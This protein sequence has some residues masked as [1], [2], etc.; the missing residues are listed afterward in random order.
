[1]SQESEIRRH[2]AEERRKNEVTKLMQ[3]L[4][5]STNVMGGD[6][7]VAAGMVQGIMRSHRT[8]QQSFMR[9]F[10]MA[11]KE[12]GATEFKDPRNEDAVALAKKIGEIEAHLSFI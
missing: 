8:L 3:Q 4:I 6:E 10:V 7:L 11:M 2:I 5:D 9:C 1:M 12:Y